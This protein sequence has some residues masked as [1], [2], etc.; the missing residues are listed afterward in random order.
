[1]KNWVSHA[2]RAF[3]IYD[4]V[5]WIDKCFDDFSSLHQSSSNEIDWRNLRD[6]FNDILIYS[7]NKES[8]VKHVRKILK[9]LCKYN[10]YAKFSK[11]DFFVENVEYLEF[12]IT[13]DDIA[14][15]TWRV[16]IVRDWSKFISY[17]N[18]QVF[19]KFANFYRCFIERYFKITISFID[20]LKSMQVEKK[21][22]T[23]HF[24]ENIKRVFHHF[25]DVFIK[26]FIL[27]HYD[28]EYKIRMKTNTFNFVIARIL[29][30]LQFD[31]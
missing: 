8:Y 22:R 5:I 31:A 21:K 27:I 13:R 9:R 25:R 20:F 15:N 7:S 16:D 18:I 2:T 30:Q 3:Q 6:L 14:M 12:M 23:F 10:F 17:K 26:T 24:I 11:C 1:M 28:S 19:L 4:Y 29:S